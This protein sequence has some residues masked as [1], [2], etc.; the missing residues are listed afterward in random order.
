MRCYWPTSLRNLLLWFI[1]NLRVLKHHWVTSDFVVSPE[2]VCSNPWAPGGVNPSDSCPALPT[3]VLCKAASSHALGV[4]H[5]LGKVGRG[6]SCL[7]VKALFHWD[8]SREKNI[9]LLSPA[10]V[11]YHSHARKL[12]PFRFWEKLF[13]C[14]PFLVPLLVSYILH[15]CSKNRDT[16]Q[17]FMTTLVAISF[18]YSQH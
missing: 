13:P 9:S 4:T 5:S 18:K 7:E 11:P 16:V 15:W 10:L 2:L 8:C 3:A 12:W 1:L 6:I 14:G 17:N